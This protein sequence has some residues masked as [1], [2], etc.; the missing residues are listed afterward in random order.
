ME[1]FVVGESDRVDRCDDVG[2]LV[3]GGVRRGKGSEV[4][5]VDR[6]GSDEVRRRGE[7]GKGRVGISSDVRVLELGNEVRFISLG[8]MGEDVEGMGV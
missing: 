1:D 4:D 3:W 6:G 8:G 7:V 2:V 5:R